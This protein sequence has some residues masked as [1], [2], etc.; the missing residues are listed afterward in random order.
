MNANTGYVE[1]NQ[2]FRK[3]GKSNDEYK[4]EG[5]RF[6]GKL[7]LDLLACQSGLV[8]G[9]KVEIEVKFVQLKFLF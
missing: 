9:T 6:F 1:R 8:P 4:S 3:N 2:L 7:Q 5:V